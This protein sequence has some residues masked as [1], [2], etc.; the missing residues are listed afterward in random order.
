MTMLTLVT[1]GAGFVGR[2]LAAALR[3]R[4]E[5][6]RVFD[7]A[8]PAHDDDIQGSVTDAE[9]VRSAMS[10]VGSVFHLAGNAQLWARNPRM[11]DEVN[12]R[13]T[14]IVTAAALAARVQ[15]FVHCASLTTLVGRKTP[16]GVSSADETTHVAIDDMLGAYP[17]SKGRADAAVRRAIDAGLDAITAIPTEPLGP[18]DHA[19][20][21]PTKMILDFARGATP[22]YI[23]CILNFVPTK[24]LADGLIAARDR[25]AV[26]ER[27]IFGGEN[28]PMAMLLEMIATRAGRA[29]PKTR[30]PYWVALAAGIVDTHIVAPV[31]NKPPA[32]PL[33]G[34][35]LAGRRVSFSSEK[36]ARELGWRAGSL[37]TA[38]DETFSWFR[39]EGLLALNDVTQ[40]ES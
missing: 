24:S 38:L 21:P 25:G 27:Y 32:A 10:N 12:N 4:G 23:D 36:A 29:A 34:V 3:A 33:T 6:V 8:A 1:G 37:S 28:T 11:F 17:Q 16:I 9:A 40:L 15:R 14:E 2:P 7:L 18:G 5:R 35:R 19:M 39:E 13:G 30:L 31:T 26:G 22:A 20:T